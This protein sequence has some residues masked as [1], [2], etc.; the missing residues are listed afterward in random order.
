VLAL[1]R[2]KRLAPALSEL[3]KQRDANAD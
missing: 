3:K 1:L 2:G